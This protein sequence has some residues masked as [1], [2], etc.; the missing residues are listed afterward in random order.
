[1]TKDTYSDDLS[2]FA[3]LAEA[4]TFYLEESFHYINKCLEAN[5]TGFIF[6]KLLMKVETTDEDDKIIKSTKF[7]ENVMD[8]LTKEYQ[9]LTEKTHNKIDLAWESAQKIASIGNFDFEKNV[10]ID[11]VELLGH[12]NNFAFFFET[13]VNRHLLFLNLTDKLDNFTYNVLD[14]ATILTR[15]TYLFK[16]ELR[17]KKIMLDDVRFLFS[18]RNKTVH[19]TPDH[20]IKLEVKL[21]ELIRIW[22]QTSKI[23]DIFQSKESFN[24]IQFSNSINEHMMHIEKRWLNKNNNKIRNKLE[25]KNDGD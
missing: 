11:S 3:R 25:S 12:L 10:K 14:K 13:L 18:L 20:A 9:V 2:K 5:L 8:I 17:D 6:D 4:A 21:E 19:Y 16:E 1:M 24:E 7:T 22:K 23:T 15:L